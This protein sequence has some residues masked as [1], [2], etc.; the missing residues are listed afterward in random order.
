MEQLPIP[1]KRSPVKA[2]KRFTAKQ[3]AYILQHLAN[4]TKLPE[5]YNSM[6]PVAWEEEYGELGIAISYRA[7]E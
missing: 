7:F 3:R 6:E 4:F 1:K 2:G 5:L